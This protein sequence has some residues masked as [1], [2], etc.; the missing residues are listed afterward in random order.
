MLA[1]RY[2]ERE[3]AEDYRA[4]I[5]ASLVSAWTRKKPLQPGDMFVSL[6]AGAAGVVASGRAQTPQQQIAIFKHLFS[7]R[8]N[9]TS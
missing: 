3:R 7:D 2:R 4:A 8:L 1:D 9:V 6:R 5:V